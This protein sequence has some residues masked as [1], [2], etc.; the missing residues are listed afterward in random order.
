MMHPK[1]TAAAVGLAAILPFILGIDGGDVHGL[2]DPSFWS[3]VAKAL[4][5]ALGSALTAVLVGAIAGAG[6][7]AFAFG[8]SRKERGQRQL[9]DADPSND[10]AGELNVDVGE[11]LMAFGARLDP[12]KRA[13]LAL[14]PPRTAEVPSDP[15]LPPKTAA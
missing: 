5:A 9:A 2:A 7:F 15:T 13:P 11:G 4:G 8:K 1:K 3:L 10:S 6:S 14:A 12:S